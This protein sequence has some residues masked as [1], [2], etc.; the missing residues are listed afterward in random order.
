MSLSA[1]VWIAIAL[2]ASV[3]VVQC[4]ATVARALESETKRRKLA[5]Q[6]RALR[7]QGIRYR[8]AALEPSCGAVPLEA[9]V[10]TSPE[11]FTQAKTH[12]GAAFDA[13]STAER[14]DAA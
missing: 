1:E 13:R 3:T 14:V 7:E 2:I 6:V 5:E 12:P 8:E 4:L 11:P 9:D 10:I